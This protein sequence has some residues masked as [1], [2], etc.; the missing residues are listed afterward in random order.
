ML[1]KIIWLFLSIFGCILFDALFIRVFHIRPIFMKSTLLL[2]LICVVCVLFLKKMN[3]YE[4]FELFAIG[5][6]LFCTGFIFNFLGPVSIERSVSF[7][8]AVAASDGI[9][10]NRDLFI[11]NAAEYYYHKKSMELEDTQLASVKSGKLTSMPM[12]KIFNM[13]FKIVG[14]LTG[15]IDGYERFVLLMSSSPSQTVLYDEE[16][17]EK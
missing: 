17:H 14:N 12:G 4:K 2:L 9:D 11:K 16:L 15:T 7:H 8:L 6:I 5:L 1:Q 13:V 3:I 10:V